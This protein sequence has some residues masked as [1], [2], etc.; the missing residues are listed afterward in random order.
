MKTIKEPNAGPKSPLYNVL[1]WLLNR[2]VQTSPQ[3]SMDP[4]VA[5]GSTPAPFTL[6]SLETV[7][8]ST[9][10]HFPLLCLQQKRVLA[11]SEIH[12]LNA[13]RVAVGALLSSGWLRCVS[14]SSPIVSGQ[15]LTSAQSYRGNH[16][17]ERCLR[18]PAPPLNEWHTSEV[19]VLAS[20][21]SSTQSLTTYCSG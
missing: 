4:T 19:C 6:I 17:P 21:P 10:L 15:K 12:V 16:T 5:I 3:T 1:R 13:N 11:V 2:C 20:L 7:C 9:P 14:S 18:R 8:N